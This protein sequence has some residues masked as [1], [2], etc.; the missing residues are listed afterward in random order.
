[1]PGFSRAIGCAYPAPA[2][3]CRGVRPP[4]S[5]TRGANTC[6]WLNG[7]LS[8]GGMMPTT[9]HGWPLSVMVSPTICS[10]P[11]NRVCHSSW[12]R[13]H[14]AG[15]FGRSSSRVKLRPR[16]GRMPSVGKKDALTRWLLSCWGSPLPVS[17]KLSNAEMPIDENDVACARISS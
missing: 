6:T 16:A 17:V 15:P 12:L 14:T 3:T 10:R 13:M 8:R 4:T 5:N 2:C 9:S 11:P 7:A 1:M